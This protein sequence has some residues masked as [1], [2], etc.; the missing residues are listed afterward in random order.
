MQMAIGHTNI[1]A[2]QPHGTTHNHSDTVHMLHNRT[3]GST[4]AD[5]G[6][7]GA[8]PDFSQLDCTDDSNDGRCILCTG[9]QVRV[10][11]YMCAHCN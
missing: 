10:C 9:F 8:A 6:P 5:T 4:G 7:R 2:L 11:V 3:S 1:S